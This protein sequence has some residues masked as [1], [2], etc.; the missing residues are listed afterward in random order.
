[1]C[2][3]QATVMV[4]RSGAAI[5]P[6]VA[7][8]KGI[9]FAASASCPRTERPRTGRRLFPFYDNLVQQREMRAAHH[10]YC[11]F[12]WRADLKTARAPHPRLAASA[13]SNAA[14]CRLATPQFAAAAKL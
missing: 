12:D 5:L 13:L 6:I 10:T 4:R 7:E 14:A 8:I 1:M 11:A 9:G 3:P 2:A